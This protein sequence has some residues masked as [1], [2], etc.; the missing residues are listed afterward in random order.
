MPARDELE[1]IYYNLK[2]STQLNTTSS[3]ANLNAVPSRASNYTAGD[4]AQTS[5]A[6]FQSGGAEAFETEFYWAST[7]FSTANGWIQNFNDGEQSNVQK[8]S[9]TYVRAVRRVAI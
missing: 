6:L 9:T 4:P 2:P 7:Q 3:G 8:L 5:V 1:V